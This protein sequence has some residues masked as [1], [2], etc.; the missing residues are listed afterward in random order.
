M[1]RIGRHNEHTAAAPGHGHRSR[2]RARGLADAA[3]TAEEGEV[4]RMGRQK[5]KKEKGKTKK[6]EGCLTSIFFLITF[7]FDTGDLHVVGGHGQSGPPIA[8]DLAYP[9]QHV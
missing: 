8:F 6:E 9:G 7:Q 5:R 1:R 4:W 3:F 2:C